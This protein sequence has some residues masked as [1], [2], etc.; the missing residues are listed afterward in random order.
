MGLMLQ[1]FVV[2]KIWQSCGRGDDSMSVIVGSCG[3]I[4][5]GW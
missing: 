5:P 2:V 3:Y 1:I 4:V